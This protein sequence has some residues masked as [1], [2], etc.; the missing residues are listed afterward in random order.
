M[1]MN[2]PGRPFD[3]FGL[4]LIVVVLGLAV[5]GF[6]VGIVWLRRIFSVDDDSGDWWR[7]R[8]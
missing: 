1:F 5:I 4:P 3:L 2:P 6:I 7:F 8:R